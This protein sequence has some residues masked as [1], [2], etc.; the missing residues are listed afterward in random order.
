MV[1]HVGSP[2]TWE[3]EAGGHKFKDKSRIYNE[4]VSKKALIK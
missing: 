1:A 2:N 4:T 3:A